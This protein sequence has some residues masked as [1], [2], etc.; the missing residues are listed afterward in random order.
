MFLNAVASIIRKNPP[1]KNFQKNL[2]RPQDILVDLSVCSSASAASVAASA[3][4]SV[5]TANEIIKTPAA[6]NAAAASAEVPASAAP[7]GREREEKTLCFRDPSNP[8]HL[9]RILDGS[10]RRKA[11]QEP[12]I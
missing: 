10:S 8:S 1:V 7:H 9:L 11:D 6:A 4:A 2:M 5:T 3:A 12:A